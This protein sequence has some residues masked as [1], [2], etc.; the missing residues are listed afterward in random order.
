MRRNYKVIILYYFIF[1]LSVFGQN[2]INNPYT[3]FALGD[4][5]NT[6]FS[7]NKSVGGSSVAL[8]PA[9]QINYL[10]P[11][12]YTSQDTMSFL[13]QGGLSGRSSLINTNL[14]EDK[15]NNFNLE[16]LAL[17][18]PITKWW[19]FSVGLVPYSRINYLFREYP[20]EEDYD[21]LV[22]DYKGSG[23]FNEFYFG[24]AYEIKDFLSI[25]LNACYLFGSLDKTR[26]VD[27]INI[28]AQYT[29]PYEIVA[30]TRLTENYIAS[31]FY[32]RFGLQAYET[33]AEKH[34]IIVGATFDGKT[35]IKVKENSLST[36]GFY[37]TTTIYVDTLS[38]VSD[39]RGS[40]TLPVKYGFGVSYIF[41][42]KLLVTTQYSFQDFSKS[43]INREHENL[44]KYQSVRFGMEY[45]PVPLTKRQR[46]SYLKRMHYR[47]GAHYTNTYLN[48]AGTQINDYGVS[49]GLGFPWRN[50]SKLYTYSSFNLSY[51]Y[52][53]RGTTENGLIKENYHIVTLGFTLHDFW[54]RKPKY[55]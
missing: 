42:E 32:F 43:T 15:T 48:I 9:N 12:S 25:G 38:V 14:D 36:R 6:G 19:K 26:T 33:F 10:N 21:Y 29:N 4:L 1:P 54:F 31:D 13:F 22:I 46:A 17:G 23:G 20:S 3:R 40:F 2:Y 24:T 37:N 7:Y 50:P 35:K 16:Y 52:G 11:A 28:N 44:S 34:K 51:E 53:V 30:Y 47:L 27:N 39:S 55:D 18:F 5:I 41:D 49:V 8:R 45:I